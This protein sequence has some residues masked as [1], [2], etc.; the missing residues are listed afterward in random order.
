M[1]YQKVIS[2]QGELP[3][4]RFGHTTT[5]VGP[6]KVI[7]FG[8]A[9]GDVGRY[10]IT[11]DLYLFDLNTNVST[12]LNSENT[13]SPRAAHAAACVESM[14]VVVFGGATGGGSLSSDD[15]Y[16]LDLRREKQLSWITVPTTGRSPGRRYGHTMVF[17]KPNLVVI[18]GNDGQQAS[19][20]VWFLNVEK[21]PFCWVEVVFPPNLKQP[22]KRV[23]HSADLCREGPAATMIVIFGGRCSDNR[24]LNDIW[25]L[26][27]HRDSTWDWM[28]A[29]VR[30]VSMPEP[31]YQHSSCFVGTKLVI[32]GGRNDSD[33][34]KPLSISAYDTETLEWFN[35]SAIHRFRHSS[36]S[37]GGQV[38]IFGGF[39]HQTQKHPTTEL[40]VIDCQEAFADHVKASMDSN[41]VTRIG[42]PAVAVG[43]P[44][45][46]APPIPTQ[47]IIQPI[48]PAEREIRLSSHAHAVHDSVS[49][50]SYLVR[51]I[52][53]DKLEEEGRKINK[54]EA[55]SQ[56][57][58][59]NDDTDT[60]YDRVIRALLNPNF[61]NDY[62]TMSY[63]ETAFPIAY[64]DVQALCQLVYQIVQ[65]ED[66]VLT[67]R[68]PIK[69]YGDIHGQYYDLMRLFRLY[70]CPLE[71][72]LAESIGAIG[73]IDSNDYL[74]LGDYV[75]R[76]S[77]N[78][79]VICLLFALK[80]KY[81]TQIHM[82]RG[83]HEDPGINAIYGFQDECR[84]RL[85][86]DCENPYSCW[87]SFNKIFEMLPLG[88]VI[89]K[90]ILCVH[91][92]IGKSIQ[93]VSDIEE[94][95]RPIT[96]APVP[97]NEQDQKILDILWSDPTDSD[98]VLGTV[99]NEVRDPEKFGHIVKFG[100]DRV[101]K[102][103]TTNDL[104]LIIRAHECVMDGFE[105][106]AGGRLITLFSATN[107]C[108]HY[109]N[110]GALLFIRRDLTIVPK[111]IYPSN[112]DSKNVETWDM[113]MA[114]LRPPT[115]PRSAPRMRETNYGA[116]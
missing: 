20:D 1:A 12:K 55:R 25:G 65:Q 15:L 111:L 112:S 96:V 88:A 92:G 85:R 72:S 34:N 18:G 30:F 36:W 45:V 50:F 68:A 48:K 24:S 35:M 5:T 21:S 75:D 73:D 100:P 14:Q 70:K 116:P 95:V 10:T 43:V 29:P 58:W 46:P 105:R 106:F 93:H 66:T 33:F 7:L 31:R 71:E 109:K 94:L 41:N 98:A 91:G 115:P 64:E 39:S 82:L 19:N 9:I 51:K 54:P 52:S 3:Q 83:N 113:H 27:Q 57:R 40:R 89:E 53:I 11:A 42:T 104:Q 26:R 86:E 84:R 17:C 49:D 108:N 79:E 60:V 4:A 103:L 56:L 76:G 114:E 81:P 6:G 67:L 38:Y 69:V 87:N 63:N 110:A 90:K 62:V 13:P 101:H 99:P 77:N 23:Y 22:P 107:Y 16:L 59:Q 37:I 47:Q 78:L 61:T 44:K 80:C 74:F 32:I 2:L 102:F 97:K 8:G 28:E